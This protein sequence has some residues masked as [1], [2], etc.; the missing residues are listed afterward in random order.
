MKRVGPLS[1]VAAGLFVLVGFVG[2]RVYSIATRS[3]R[4]IREGQQATLVD[5]VKARLRDVPLVIRSAGIV[6]TDHS[7]S[8]QAQ[9]AGMLS[10]VLFR[11]G[12]EVKAGQLLFVINPA[13]YLAQVEA[14]Q[15]Q[16]EQDEA[17]IAI[18]RANA[19]RMARLI[20]LG[21]VSTQQNEDAEAT[22]KQDEGTLT[23]D[24]AKLEEA[25]LQLGYTQIHAPISGKTGAISYK[26]GNL[27]QANGS[28]PLV[29]INQIEPILVQ[30][31]IPQSQVPTLMKYRR[32]KALSVSIVR[33]DG[34]SIAS[35]GSLTFIN[36]LIDES[37]G[38][39]ELKARFPNR[40]RVL[41]PG[42]LVTVALTLTIQNHVVVVP[43]IAVQPGQDGSY[44]YTI[45]KGRAVIRKVH[46]V[47]VYNGLAIVSS[48]LKPGAPIIVNIPR[49]LH[50]GAPIIAARRTANP[51]DLSAPHK[52]R[53]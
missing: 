38:T 13:P 27:I 47:R 43:S 15:G 30:F 46:I 41:W 16:V 45:A 32:G 53:P 4:P 49:T 52:R 23:A 48:G 22:V 14:A 42:E 44:V 5:T 7:V 10:K 28:P 9:V 25:K 21:Y 51:T 1:F 6:Q 31:S 8:I 29:T 18:D 40:R 26:T 12:E 19:R 37:T 2:W 11:E 35:G 24:R 17:K 36:N 3:Y 34:K 50:Q 33:G 39:L 20:H